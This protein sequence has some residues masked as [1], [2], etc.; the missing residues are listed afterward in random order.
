VN[1]LL[2]VIASLAVVLGFITA[3]LG[4]ANQ[5]RIRH[6]ASDVQQISVQVDGRLSTLLER[7]AQ[8]LDA[9]HQS[10]TPVP[11]IPPEPG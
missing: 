6:T 9:L 11:P 4:L 10:G 8:L 5:R 7:Q 1:A 2:A 3:V